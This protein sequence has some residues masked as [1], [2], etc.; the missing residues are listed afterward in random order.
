MYT[1]G[2]KVFAENII[3][4]KK[5]DLTQGKRVGET[6]IR[7]YPPTFQSFSYPQLHTALVGSFEALMQ[8]FRTAFYELLR[9]L[10]L[11]YSTSE[12]PAYPTRSWW[13]QVRYPLVDVLDKGD[14]YVVRAELPGF[15]RE[16]VD[17]LANRNVLQIRAERK[18][19]AEDGAYLH[20]EILPEVFQR[21]ITF[22]DEI[23]P[24]KIE[25]AMKDGILEI[26]ILKSGAKLEESMTKVSVH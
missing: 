18:L 10:Y 22:P 20:R 8:G 14:Y 7:A 12:W 16:Q 11:D 5:E 2:C 17:V 15:S 21:T 1:G 24:S 4:T 6:G 23:V 19:F 3:L 9:P 13:S 25:A 26:R